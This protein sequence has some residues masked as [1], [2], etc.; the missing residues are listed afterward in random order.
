M[1]A[2]PGS[3]KLHMHVD[4]TERGWM[5]ASAVVLVIFGIA[6]AVAGFML[7]IQ[8]PTEEQR[9][10]PGTI[11][12]EPEWAAP[13]AGE[14]DLRVQ[15]L[16]PGSK[17]V[18]H[19]VAQMWLFAPNQIPIPDSGLEIPVGAEV[20]FYV[21]SVD[22]QHGFKLQ[23]TNINFMAIPG[24]VSTLTTTFK[25]PGKYDFICTEYCG[26]GH[27]AMYGSITITG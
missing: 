23:N 9:V 25:E 2:S 27:A 16:A 15:E 21:T 7:G 19:I 18:V 20:T 24:E 12:N 14:P 13:A 17:Y 6:I 4:P 10:D 11:A 1:S 3:E 26:T 5:R 8:V 22:V